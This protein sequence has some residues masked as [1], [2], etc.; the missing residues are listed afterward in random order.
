[1]VNHIFKMGIALAFWSIQI[2]QAQFNRMEDINCVHCDAPLVQFNG[3]LYFVTNTT[4]TIKLFKSD[5]SFNGKILVKEIPRYGAG[6]NGITLKVINNVLCIED[7]YLL[8]AGGG[9][10]HY[11]LWVSDGTTVGTVEVYDFGVNGLKYGVSGSNVYYVNGGVNLKL[12]NTN[13]QLLNAGGISNFVS[14]GTGNVYFAAGGSVYKSNGTAAGTTV[15]INSINFLP[16]YLQANKLY[17]GF[18]P[19]SGFYYT[20]VNTPN[21]YTNVAN[22]RLGEILFKDNSNNYVYYLNGYNDP[23]TPSGDGIRLYRTDGTATGT[24]KL[25]DVLGASSIGKIGSKYFYT[26]GQGNDIYQTDGTVAGTT[27]FYSGNFRAATQAGTTTY[28]WKYNANNQSFNLWQTDG[29]TAGTQVV[30]GGNHRSFV[31]TD[32]LSNSISTVWYNGALY[33]YSGISGGESGLYKYVG[34]PAPPPA[35]A[36]FVV[37]S[38]TVCN[39]NQNPLYTVS[40]VLEATS[41]TWSYSG[42]AT[43]YNPTTAGAS[44]NLYFTSTSTAGTL[45]VR[46]VNGCGT[47]TPLTLP[48]VVKSLPVQ[49]YYAPSNPAQ[50]CAGKSIVLTAN[51]D[52]NVDSY[53]YSYVSGTGATFGSNT[54]PVTVSFAANATS[55]VVYATPVNSCGTGLTKA[56]SITIMNPPQPNMASYP[57]STTINSGE[58]I[59]LYYN[60]NGGCLNYAGITWSSGQTGSSIYVGPTTTTTYTFTCTNSCDNLV[61]SVPITVTVIGGCPPTLIVNSSTT[62]PAKAGDHI[63]T[64]GTINYT[65][66]SR[67][68]QAGKAITITPPTGGNGF[69]LTEKGTVFEAKIEGCP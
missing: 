6:V 7:T 41:Y 19:S 2:S 42:S 8:Y 38:E 25:Q 31:G 17:L 12:H 30:V 1:M 60:D 53:N 58:Y 3:S 18:D 46:A 64:S 69:W 68:Y 62:S 24:I 50:A 59:S 35:P 27:L 55:G 36:N 65:S 43:I 15:H 16:L 47:S 67:L 48:I 49:P 44:N 20:D 10:P 32:F 4:A 34:C 61:T 45:S 57:A 9:S 56:R 22:T 54:N 29:T 33:F 51:T 28:L 14:D 13:T 52:P 5:G 26:V 11:A 66:G 37:K 63:T 40:S 21:S 39:N 23:P